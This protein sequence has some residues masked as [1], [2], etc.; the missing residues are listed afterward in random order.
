MP[1]IINHM[2][3]C[4]S[5]LGWLIFILVITQI[6]ACGDSKN[7]P[8]SYDYLTDH[9]IEIIDQ[10]VR[11]AS[12]EDDIGQLLMVG[13]PADLNTAEDTDRKA[14][15][16]LISDN[17]VGMV[18]VNGYNYYDNSKDTDDKEYLTRVI[19]FNNL[20]QRKTRKS[21]NKFPLLI[22]TDFE[23]PSTPSVKRGLVLPPSALSLSTTQ[24]SQLIR[25][26]GEY[27]GTELTNVG[28]QIILGPVLDTNN[29]KQGTKNILQDRC[30][31]ANSEGVARTAS[32]Y[33][34]GLYE[35]GIVVFAKHY[36]SH[37]SIESDPHQKLIPVYEGSK[38][39][40]AQ[41]LKPFIQSK[42]NIRGV[43]TSHILLA[44]SKERGMATFNRELIDDLRGQGLNKQI[45][46]TD[47]LSD[48]GAIRS[49]MDD[50][51]KTYQDTAVDAFD[52]GHDVLLFA[53]IRDEKKRAS[54]YGETYQPSNFTLKE[55]GLVRNKLVAHIGSSEFAKKRF[56]E[57]LRK[58]LILK[59]QVAKMQSADPLERFFS[60]KEGSDTA[61][62]FQIITDGQKAIEK[63]E[64]VMAKR[65]EAFGLAVHSAAGVGNSLVKQSIKKSVI[66]IN[67]KNGIDINLL[68]RSNQTRIIFAAYG[69]QISKFK[70]A[71]SAHFSN[72]I[73]LGIPFRK[74]TDSFSNLELMINATFSKADLLIYTVR[75]GSDVDLLKRL[76]NK[77]GKSYSSK[78]VIFLHNSPAIFGND[79]LSDSTVVGN[80]TMHPFAFDVD[81]EMLSDPENKPRE[82]FNIPINIGDNGKF[83]NVSDTKWVEPA[84]PVIFGELFPRQSNLVTRESLEK[85][86]FLISRPKS[87]DSWVSA[88]S[89][90]FLFLLITIIS[91]LF[92]WW[93]KHYVMHA[94]KAGYIMTG[95]AHPWLG[96]I[97]A[98]GIFLVLIFIAYHN[99]LF[100]GVLNNAKEAS[101]VVQSVRENL[102][103]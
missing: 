97:T 48:M 31:A 76:R 63:T 14:L 80:F 86:F 28:I 43:M 88:A 37:G 18:I 17:G 8:V 71:F 25:T 7:K 39:Q 49:Y 38:L 82:L 29:V 12:A 10:Y 11:S 51:H 100:F 21:I 91:I 20:L 87:I 16:A 67:N 27:V 50:N 92:H 26:V 2:R 70:D 89:G 24:D 93:P 55:L 52:A 103:R 9:D 69:D 101:E 58:V 45:V 4:Q 102:Q 99:T 57:S 60:K 74:D 36:P 84:N 15:D 85:N 77:Y 33:I 44:S 90:V 22:A 30:F 72:A 83:Y 41:E 79:M 56:K 75:D 61:F 59:A 95:L 78:A 94:P 5:I 3:L 65:Q 96:K 42:E 53:H 73:F 81:V 46:I 47:D 1:L 54:S 19:N 34:S 40:M 23:N 13:V 35:S 98:A 6:V 32:H 62:N 68:N 66:W 64:Q